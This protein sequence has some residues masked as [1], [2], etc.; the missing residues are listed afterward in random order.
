VNLRHVLHVFRKDGIEILRDRRTL[1]VNV[2]LPALLYPLIALFMLQVT[3]L[4]RNQVREA[5]RVALIDVP[6]RASE[7]LARP[8]PGREGAA[9]DQARRPPRVAT[10]TLPSV[11]TGRLRTLALELDAVPKDDEERARRLRGELLEQ[12]RVHGLAGAV[13]LVPREEASDPA[14]WLALYD[15]AD[16]R[17]DQARDAVDDAAAD[18]GRELAKQR[19]AEAG[20]PASLLA[21][22][23]VATSRLASVAEEVRTRISGMIPLLLVILAAVGAFYPAIDLIA[24]ERERGTLESLLSWP[25]ARRDLFLGKLLVTCAAAGASVVLNLASLALTM[26]LAGRQLAQ[27]GADLGGALSTGLG[28]LAVCVVVLVPLT[29]TLG[30]LSLALAGLA[31]SAKEAQNYLSPMLLVVMVAALVAAVPEARPSLALDLIPIT[32][33][34]LALKESL[35]GHSLPWLH[36]LL[37]TG[38]SVCLAAVVVGWATRLLDS[39]KFRYPGLVRAGW[40]R[41]RRWGERPAVPDGV[42][43][44]GVFAVAVAGMTLGAGMFLG[45]PVPLMIGGP[46]LLF[47]LGPALAHAWLGGYRRDELFSLR[48][49]SATDAARGLVAVPFAI[50]VSLGIASLQGQPAADGDGDGGAEKLLAQLASYGV[51]VEL[52][53]A[54]VA[55]AV[56]EELL[57]RGTLLAGLKRSLGPGAAA[58]VSAF[59]FAA[60]HLSPYRFLPQFALGIALAALTLRTR[61]I[62]PAMLLHAGHNGAVLL[63]ERGGHGALL[64]GFH[65]LAALALG[66][67]G[68]VAVIGMRRRPAA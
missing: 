62:G 61:S 44:M 4:T 38:S 42:E 65:P 30:A 27:A 35:Q 23:T 47:V 1:F 63:I 64:E 10:V 49:P 68:L 6:A 39:E 37:A 24:G 18:Y 26:T 3:Q 46:L 14:R 40:G 53:C 15:T 28:S 52:L 33:S 59:L 48:T 56:C 5:P 21:P 25:V 19:L 13:V 67:L 20:L 7:L 8:L 34:V 43:A 57:C 66:G 31:A 12:L 51:L 32:G 22:V 36:L 54:A 58:V 16:A 9:K 60:L 55:P 50:L 11:D 45:S 41:F 17:H 29:L 2:V